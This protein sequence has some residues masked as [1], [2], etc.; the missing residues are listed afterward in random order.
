MK[1]LM[2]LCLCVPFFTSGCSVDA[3]QPS[4]SP[5]AASLET[6]ELLV[7]F[8][9]DIS[10]AEVMRITEDQGTSVVRQ[11]HRNL[12]LIRIPEGTSMEDAIRRLTARPEVVYAE[13]N[14]RHRPYTR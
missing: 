1:S 5:A 2:A 4:D 9:D 10:R 13:P 14:V 8:A 6:G 12:Y 7:R 3:P 11:Q